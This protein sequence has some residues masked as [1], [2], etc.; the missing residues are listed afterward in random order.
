MM[1]SSNCC[2]DSQIDW[3]LVTIRLAKLTLEVVDVNLLHMNGSH[4]RENAI[5]IANLRVFRIGGG[6]VSRSC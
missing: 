3:Y 4:N 6:K 5:Y 2:P 1:A